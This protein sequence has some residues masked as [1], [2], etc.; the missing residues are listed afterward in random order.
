MMALACNPNYSREGTRRIMSLITPQAKGSEILFQKQ[1]YKK[2]KQKG[3]DVAQ[4]V[5]HLPSMQKTLGSISTT[6]KKKLSD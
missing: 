2:S 1:N 6:E 3:E 4:V 5:E